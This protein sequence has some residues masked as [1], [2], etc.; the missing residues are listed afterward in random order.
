MTVSTTDKVMVHCK[1]DTRRWHDVLRL[2]RYTGFERYVDGRTTRFWESDGSDIYD[3]LRQV[4]VGLG[5]HA[6]LDTPLWAY[7]QL[8]D[9]SEKE[10]NVIDEVVE[11]VY[12]KKKMF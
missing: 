8:L 7:T 1:V 10:P 5:K 3:C 9:I 2:H 11:I 12:G 6:G 4:A